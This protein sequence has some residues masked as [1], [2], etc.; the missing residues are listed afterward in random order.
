VADEE[1]PAGSNRRGECR[2][3]DGCEHHQLSRWHTEA[4][5]AGRRGDAV[6]L[7]MA[8]AGMPTDQIRAMRTEPFWPG[9]EA[10]APTLAYDH[11]AILGKDASVPTGRAARVAVPALV[12]YGDASYPFMGETA[13]TLSQ[14]IP[15]A[16][17]RT[18]AGQAHVVNP[19]VLAPV[20]I[21]FFT[22]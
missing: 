4:L 22:S 19:G 14:A 17:L 3:G 13:R 15:H 11:A 18:L 21:Q 5:A 2:A 16:E 1:Q 12:M 9:M 8:S 10:I 7:F 6:A 20:L